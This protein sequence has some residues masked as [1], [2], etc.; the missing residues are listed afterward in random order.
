MPSIEP[1]P[2]FSC[3]G[4]IFTQLTKNHM[5]EVPED[6][7]PNVINFFTNTHGSKKAVVIS[8]YHIPCSLLEQGYNIRKLTVV[9]RINRTKISTIEQCKN[10]LM[11]ILNSHKSDP[12][13]KR[14][15]FI[16]IV[17]ENE[18]LIMDVSLAFKIEML[19]EMTPSFK[20]AFSLVNKLKR[21]IDEI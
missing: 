20:K 1:I 6:V 17:T 14:Y 16:E 18:T 3:G 12:D 13:N 21:K 5:E 19:L 10:I 15:K 8:S 7:D 9:K 11:K 2:C 4:L